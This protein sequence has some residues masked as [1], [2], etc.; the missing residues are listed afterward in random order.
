[1]WNMDQD[2]TRNRRGS[3]IWAMKEAVGAQQADR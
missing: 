3:A 1:M 2:D